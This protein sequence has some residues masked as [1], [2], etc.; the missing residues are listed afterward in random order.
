VFIVKFLDISKVQLIVVLPEVSTINLLLTFK[1]LL[2]LIN[3]DVLI[4]P[5]ISINGLDI[6]CILYTSDTKEPDISICSVGCVVPKPILLL[7]VIQNAEFPLPDCK[8]K[9]VLLELILYIYIN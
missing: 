8:N 3:P 9:F 4:L 6:F 2:I 1:L 7:G 5:L